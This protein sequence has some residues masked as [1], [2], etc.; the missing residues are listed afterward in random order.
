VRAAGFGT[1]AESGIGPPIVG[2]E[3]VRWRGGTSMVHVFPSANANGAHFSALAGRRWNMRSR[4]LLASTTLVALVLGTGSI[5]VAKRQP[6][7]PPSFPGA[8][9]FVSA[10]DNPFFPLPPGTTYSFSGVQDGVPTSDVMHVNRK[11][12]EI[13]GVDCTEVHDQAFENGVLV[14]DTLD[15]YAQDVDGSVWYFGEDTKELDAAG[16]VVSTEGSWQAGVNGAQPGVIMEASPQVGDLYFQEFSEGVAEDVAEVVS[17]DGSTCVAYGCFD[18]VLVT[19]EW[20]PLEPNVVEE[21]S[22]ASGIGFIRAE[23]IKGGDEIEELVAIH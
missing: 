18:G 19:R 20:S 12:K 13:L 4:R 7:E 2:N 15:W 17:L 1:S 6:K 23:T 16:N 11:T 9:S 3:P 8:A 14:E 5:A 22:Y 21:K 10:V